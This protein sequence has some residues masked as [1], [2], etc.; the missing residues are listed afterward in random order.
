[1]KNFSVTLSM[2]AIM[3]VFSFLMAPQT[4]AQDTNDPTL[5][6]STFTGS[7]N[8]VI[9][10]YENNRLNLHDPLEILKVQA[11]GVTFNKKGSNPND[12]N[13]L[14]I[15]GK[16]SGFA[17]DVLYV[18][19][20]IVDADP[21]MLFADDIESIE[22]IKDGALLSVYG[23]QGSAGV[24]I[25]KTKHYKG[26][27]K[28]VVN[29]SSFI[30]L[31]TASKYMDVLTAEQFRSAI[32]RHDINFDD[33][34]SNTD[35][36]KELMRK[37]VSQIYSLGVSGKLNSTAYDFSAFFDKNPGIVKGSS[38]KNNGI[39][40]KVNQSALADKLNLFANVSYNSADSEVLP[41]TDEGT[42]NLFLQT[43]TRNPTDPVFESDGVTY[44]QVDRAFSYFN[45]LKMI[46]GTVSES[47]SDN[48]RINAGGL[49]A[50][51][52]G[53]KAGINVGYS[54]LDNTYDY[55]QGTETFSYPTEEI[56]S[57]Y[58]NNKQRFNTEISVDYEKAPAENHNLSI[59]AL[60]RYRSLN[61][62]DDYSMVRGNIRDSSV[63][64]EERSYT[65]YILHAGYNYGE[66]YFVNASATIEAS[67]LALTGFQTAISQLN[68]K[69]FY[70]SFMAGWNLSNEKFLRNNT[71]IN[72][73]FLK[74]SHGIRGNGNADTQ[75][76]Y[77]TFP[78]IESLNTEK[79][80]ELSFAIDFGL[81][82][83]RVNGNLGWYSR[84]I[85]N[86]VGVNY[87]PVPPGVFY[88]TYSNN[89][90]YRSTGFEAM[91]SVTALDHK[92]IKWRSQFNF[93]LNHEE[94]KKGLP[95]H[96]SG[97]EAAGYFSYSV[98]SYATQR[99]KTG[100]PSRVF[101]LPLSAGYSDDGRPL[102]YTENGNVTREFSR[103]K[104]EMMSQSDPKYYIGWM[105]SFQML[106]NFNLSVSLSYVG[107]FS[108]YNAT[109]MYLSNPFYITSYNISEEGLANLDAGYQSSAPLSE[110]YLENASYLRVD[111]ITLSY[112]AAFNKTKKPGNLQI[113]LSARN[114][115]TVTD[116][117]GY[118]PA[119]S[120]T[121]VDYFNVYP[122]AR[123]YTI[124]LRFN[125]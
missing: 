79:I 58:T 123:T 40:I 31:N 109:R 118:D 23:T 36:Q 8:Q 114:L 122:L 26:K 56:T 74:T 101:Y 41:F 94:L 11:T 1:M 96:N 62:E 61:D 102:Y 65:N 48:L 105:N 90:S 35:W 43:L 71:R 13:T 113:Y 9:V 104:F 77:N 60:I 89:Y 51:A 28:L 24:I 92:N 33:G 125:I 115:L 19:D 42:N 14:S 30:T 82:K 37:P 47:K 39:N 21:S 83:N 64:R 76:F 78:G 49:Y 108:I 10:N 85:D 44:H 68:R 46:D 98:D 86:A 80:S 20:G 95:T 103:A 120:S 72:H 112:T 75:R 84:T 54:G 6:D 69:K 121:G 45:P 34:G 7:F 117:T 50:I 67:E 124:G 66:R 2:L 100:Y 55:H 53:L 5:K 18:I 119:G 29:F 88:Y 116:Y 4:F 111:D 27:E 107:G 12:F 91:L 52:D 99:I 25:I 73:L 57:G 70:P 22:I 97:T 15:R 87:L 32:D 81:F 17:P 106:S 93:F 3:S 110:T 63:Y 38:H 16:E 59:G